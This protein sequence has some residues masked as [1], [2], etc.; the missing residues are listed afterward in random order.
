MSGPSW[1]RTRASDLI[2][3]LKPRITALSVFMAAGGLW[4]AGAGGWTLMAGTLLGTA[5]AVGSA[6]ALNMH[7]ERDGDRLMARTAERP[8][9]AGRM[10]APVA[11]WFGVAV[12]LVGLAT[13]WLAANPLTA[14]LGALALVSYVWVYT[15][16]KRR[17]AL[18][19]VV[20][21][22]PGAAP[23]LMGWTAATGSIEGPGLVLFLVLLVW[24]IP[25]FIAISLFRKDDYARAGIVTIAGT[26]GDRAAKIQALAWATALLPVS[27]ALAPLGAA[28]W[29]Y[30]TVAMGA[31][32]WFCWMAARGFAPAAG[33]AWARSLFGASLVYLPLVVLGLTFDRLVL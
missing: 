12:G 1:L 11:L 7:L 8:L 31:G 28:S 29:L 27:L 16:L 24:Q 2:A 32:L 9:P 30:V 26:R 14:L 4:L 13:L 19:V 25:H 22:V 20:G 33:S 6:N 18:A 5:L 21:A 15:P 17:T 23:P 10:A 3:L